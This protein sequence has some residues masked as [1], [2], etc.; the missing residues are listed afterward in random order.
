M[1]DERLLIG[2]SVHQP[3]PDCIRSRMAA[4]LVFEF[5]L[6]TLGGNRRQGR[7]DVQRPARTEVSQCIW[8]DF[9]ITIR[10]IPAKPEKQSFK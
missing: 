9:S 10:P 4:L 6:P 5:R 3:S 8:T 1:C 7:A 2:R